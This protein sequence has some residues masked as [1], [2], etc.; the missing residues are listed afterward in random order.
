MKAI[1]YSRYGGP[2]VLELGEVDDPRIGPDS[3]LVKVRAAAVRP[4]TRRGRLTV[5]H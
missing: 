5:T 1:S 4:S 2:E 3:V